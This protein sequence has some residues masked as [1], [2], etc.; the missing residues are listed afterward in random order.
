MVP[1]LTKPWK[2]RNFPSLN[3]V[4]QSYPKLLK[5]GYACFLFMQ[6]FPALHPF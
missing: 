3:P 5:T 4:H 6:S 1:A 2:A